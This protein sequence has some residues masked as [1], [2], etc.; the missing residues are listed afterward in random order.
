VSRL[1]RAGSVRTWL[2][3]ALFVGIVALTD[4]L[5]LDYLVSHGLEEKF[6]SI[7]IGTFQLSIPIIGLTFV[8]VLIVAMAA[9][10]N[11]SGTMPITALREMS[12]LETTR[13]LRA[14]G[15]ALFFF[16]AALFTPYIMGSS[17]FWVQV[18][19]LSRSIPQLAGSLQGFYSAIQ[20]VMAL[21]AIA[22]LAISQNLAA[23]A[24][25]LVS[26]LISHYQRRIRRTK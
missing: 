13:M 4:Y 25:V 15:L 11:I 22:K 24:L 17:G 12:Q 3:L 5:L 9:W 16:T 14:A 7:S 23:G 21:D 26:G 10:L 2:S 1:G 19:S 20:P 8:G 6:Q 18:S